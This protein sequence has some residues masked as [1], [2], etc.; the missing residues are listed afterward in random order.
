MS[1]LTML[2]ALAAC[3]LNAAV[4]D[5][6]AFG[7]KG[8]GKTQ[9][10]EAINKA[11]EAAAAAGGGTVEF[12]AGTWL[13]GSLRLRSNVTLRLERGAVIEASSEVSAYDEPEPNQ[14]DRFQDFGHSHFHN[15]LI[16][17]ENIENVA[18][19]GGGRISGKALTRGERGG[20]GDK[21]I[22]LKLCRN[23]TLRDISIATG[24]HFGVLA[25]GVDNLTIDNL[26]IDTNRDGIDLDSCR[27]VRISN[28][29]VNAPNDDAIVLKGS[30]ALGAARASENITITNCLVSG[31]EI[32]SL[33]DGTYKRPVQRAPDRDGPTGRIK[34]GTESEGDFRNITI[35]NVVF[36]IGRAHV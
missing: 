11:I 23:V 26:M 1:K 5:V 25:T 16:W 18:I 31:F 3:C 19:I 15:S 36:E 20:L 33:L 8:D 35:S 7:A 28:S 17:G 14:W 13:T 21:A 9:N 12:P 22:A 34:I 30:H 32:G 4:F 2:A 27:N 10:R 6:T 29:S 24:G